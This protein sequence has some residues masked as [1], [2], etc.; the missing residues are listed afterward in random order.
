MCRVLTCCSLLTDVLREQLHRLVPM[1]EDAAE[2][3]EY[4]LCD[5]RLESELLRVCPRKRFNLVRYPI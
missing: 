2:C 1:D 4:M 5:L 3:I